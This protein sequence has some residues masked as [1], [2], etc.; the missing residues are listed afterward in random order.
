MKIQMYSE[1]ILKSRRRARQAYNRRGLA[2]KF[3]T[4]RWTDLE[5]AIVLLWPN[6]DQ[7]LAYFIKRSVSSIQAQRSRLRSGQYEKP[8]DKYFKQA[9]EVIARQK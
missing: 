6:S 5:Q 7:K 8:D 1:Q 9:R 3:P 4:R 2:K